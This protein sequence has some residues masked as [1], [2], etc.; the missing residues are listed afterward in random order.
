MDGVRNETNIQP[1]VVIQV[2]DLLA[3]RGALNLPA[4]PPPLAV[5]PS[6]TW[7]KERYGLHAVVN[8]S[9]AKA[10]HGGGLMEM[11]RFLHDHEVV[12]PP[13]NTRLKLLVEGTREQAVLLTDLVFAVRARRPAAPAPGIEVYSAQLFH[14]VEPKWFYADLTRQDRVPVRPN[15]ARGERGEFPYSVHRREP[16]HFAVDLELGDQEVEWVAELHWT[17]EGNSGALEISNQG[18]PFVSRPALGRPRYDWDFN[19]GQWR[20]V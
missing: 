15:S 18:A 3:S 14:K 5:T 4:E 1:S 2:R 13:D 7:A 8:T 9:I 6:V 12:T 11:S 17:C 16:E 10:P 20:R 19:T